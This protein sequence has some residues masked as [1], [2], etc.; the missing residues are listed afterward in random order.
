VQ[1]H[2]YKSPPAVSVLS[3]MNAGQTLTPYYFRIYFSTT[4]ISQLWHPKRTLSFRYSSKNLYVFRMIPMRPGCQVCM[5]LLCLYPYDIRRSLQIT[6]VLI[7]HTIFSSLKLFLVG[8]ARLD[9]KDSFG[10]CQLRTRVKAMMKL[11]LS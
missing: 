6:I 9:L 11:R 3:E 7:L 5:K 2:V 4:P 10:L 1:Y 8:D